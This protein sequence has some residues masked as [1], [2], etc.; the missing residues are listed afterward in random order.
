MK[1]RTK[2]PTKGAWIVVEVYLTARQRVV[3]ES[4]RHYDQLATPQEIARHLRGVVSNE[5]LELDVKAKVTAR[6]RVVP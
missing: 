4:F 2:K 5:L 6:G 3:F 1:K